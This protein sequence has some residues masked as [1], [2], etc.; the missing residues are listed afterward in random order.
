MYESKRE[1]RTKENKL[2]P[3]KDAIRWSIYCF[4]SGSKK[5]K[6]EETKE[7]SIVTT[8]TTN[9]IIETTN[10]TTMIEEEDEEGAIPIEVTDDKTNDKAI[11][12]KTLPAIS[13]EPLLNILCQLDTVG[14]N[15]L[16]RYHIKWLEVEDLSEIRSRWL[17]ALLLL[18]QKPLDEDMSDAIRNL[19]RRLTQI[20]STIVSILYLYLIL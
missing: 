6:T 1:I 20:R 13:K 2:P 4:G 3:I 17:F 19:L 12:D 11:D 16:L 15:T 10:D 8:T 7:P 5:R 9:E 18:L 14:L